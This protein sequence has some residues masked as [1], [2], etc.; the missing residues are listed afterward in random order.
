MYKKPDST[1]IQCVLQ[2][3]NK[4]QTLYIPTRYSAIGTELKVNIND[5]WEYG[6]IVISA[7]K[8]SIRDDIPHVQEI[9]RR[10][11]NNT[12]DSMPKIKYK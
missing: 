8:N 9:I 3:D 2:K 10:H 1:Y 7:D 12:L 4:I 5:K 6:W 11:R